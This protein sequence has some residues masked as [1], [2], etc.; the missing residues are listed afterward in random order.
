MR[1]PFGQHF[2]T[3]LHIVARI[4]QTA[5]IDAEDTVLEIGP[6]QGILTDTLAE[7]AARLIA[8]EYDAGLAE[9]LSH[10]FRGEE[11]VHIIQADARTVRYQDILS[12][13]PPHQTQVVANLPYYAAIPIVKTLFQASTLFGRATLMFQQEVAERLTASP[14]TKRYGSLTV[15]AHYFAHVAYGFTV[16][17]K[18]FRPPPNVESAVITLDFS[19]RP[20][21]Q[22]SNSDVLF[23]LVRDAFQ[24]RRKTLKNSLRKHASRRFPQDAIENAFEQLEFHDSIRAEELSLED[25]VR[26]SH[27]LGS[28]KVSR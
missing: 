20:E 16:P 18:A 5:A 8:I 26:L 17:P 24:S 19:A 9:R 21:L 11:H 15:L 3:D 25:F 7:R 22:V 28:P 1:K 12:L 10:R 2:L 27:V 23:Q 6:G 13:S 4:M 14:G